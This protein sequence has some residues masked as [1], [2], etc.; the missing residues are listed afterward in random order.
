MFSLAGRG[1]GECS[2]GVFDLIEVDLAN[3]R[4]SL[5]AGRLYAAALSAARALLV[6]RNLQPNGDQEAFELFKTHFVGGGLV[7]AALAGVVTAGSLAASER[8]PSEAFTGRGPDVTAL[9]A[10][11]RLLYENLDASLRF[12]Q[13]L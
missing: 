11:V 8:N 1:A 3:A 12:K 10:S 4:E 5:E 2:A 7:D 9:V 6:T 13:T